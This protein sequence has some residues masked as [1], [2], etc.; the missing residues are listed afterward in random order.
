MPITPTQLFIPSI[1]VNTTVAAAPTVLAYDEFVNAKVP[2]FGVPPD[3]ADGMLTPTWWSADLQGNPEPKPGDTD[4]AIIL[5]HTQIGGPG[6][7]NDLGNLQQGAVIGV[8]DG[9]TTLKFQVISVQS[10]IPKTDPTALQN[11]L[12]GHP[13][14]AR[15]ALLTCSGH[16]NGHESV[17]N[18]L[19]F[20][21]LV[22]A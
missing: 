22:G 8:S 7:F 2:S 4:M 21:E 16:F 12:N 13:P 3:T 20:A 19:V 18:T 15:L 17:E 10:G 9:S 5:G 11:A 14:N 6:V 1:G